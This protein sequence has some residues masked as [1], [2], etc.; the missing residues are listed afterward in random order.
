MKTSTTKYSILAF[1]D[2]FIF[3]EHKQLRQHYRYFT[4]FLMHF[5]HFASW[6]VLPL[7]IGTEEHKENR[8][9]LFCLSISVVSAYTIVYSIRFENIDVFQFVC[10]NR[11]LW[12]SL[13]S[14]WN[15]AIK[16]SKCLKCGNVDVGNFLMSNLEEHHCIDEQWTKCNNEVKRFH[17]LILN[18]HKMGGREPTRN[19]SIRVSLFIEN[20]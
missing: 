17:S 6:L 19:S 9:F 1:C 7:C 4:R 16:C 12:K 20:K 5:V 18:K 8:Q 2:F 11:V 13:A 10:V 15:V 14:I 3:H